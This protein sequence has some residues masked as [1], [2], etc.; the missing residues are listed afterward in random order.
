MTHE[1]R[2]E[3]AAIGERL[4]WLEKALGL[5]GNQ[6]SAELGLT[7]QR[8]S[9]YKLGHRELSIWTAADMR[10]RWGCSLDW[11]Y[12]GEEYRNEEPLRLKLEAARQR[13]ARP[14]ETHRNR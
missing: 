3:L 4:R 12:L 7:R 13:Q 11:L 6:I 2:P 9:M 8:W 5:N 1:V 14:A 10:R